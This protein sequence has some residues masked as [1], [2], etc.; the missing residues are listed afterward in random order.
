MIKY[1]NLKGNSVEYNLEIKPVK[2]I[3]LRIKAD[4]SIY[5]SANKS[6]DEK[7]ITDFL[8][9]KSDYILNALKKYDEMLKYAENQKLYVDGESYKVFGH[10]R[11][12]VVKLSSKN[13]IVSDESYIYLFCK[14][15][16]DISIKSKTLNRWLQKQLQSEIVNICNNTYRKF[17]KY[18]IKFPTIRYRNMISRWGSCQ[19]KKGILTFNY[20]LINVP[21]ACMEYVVMHEFTHF[22]Q[23]NH[24][25]KFYNQLSMFMPDWRERKKMLDMEI[26]QGL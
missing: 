6:I 18:D 19:P 20:A 1:I 12:L 23:P 22:L 4:K 24:S 9:S 16:E 3:N 25:K 17:E 7:I 14:N 8:L 21:I 26:V 15:V 2:N 13:Y 11:R 10:N 5:V